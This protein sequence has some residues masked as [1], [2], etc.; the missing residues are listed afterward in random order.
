MKDPVDFEAELNKYLKNKYP[1][2]IISSESG[3]IGA[4]QIAR[5]IAHGK[6]EIMGIKVEL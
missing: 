1:C 6:R 3:A 4:A 5:D 2:K